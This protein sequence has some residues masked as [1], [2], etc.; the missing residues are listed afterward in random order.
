MKKYLLLC[1]EAMNQK[2]LLLLKDRQH[3]VENSDVY[4]LQDVLDIQ[5]DKLLRELAPTHSTWAQHIKTDC[6]VSCLSLF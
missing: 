6:Q 2:F 4:S 1:K 3:F 5:S